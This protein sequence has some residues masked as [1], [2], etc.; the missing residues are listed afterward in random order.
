MKRILLIALAYS[1]FFNAN[2]QFYNAGTPFQYYFDINPDT[3]LH[4]TLFPYT[5]Q[6]YDLGIFSPS[7][8]VRFVADGA[9]SSG[10]TSA[11]ISVR[12]LDANIYLSVGRLD[13]V[14][15]S[16]STSWLVTTVAKPLNA[17]EP[18]NAAGTVWDNSLL[19]ISDHSASFGWAK[20]INDWIGSDKYLGLKYDDGSTVYYGWI[21]LQ[22]VSE[23]SCYVKEYSYS[24]S[25][26]GIAETETGN[27]LIFPNPVT[28]KFTVYFNG[29][30]SVE[31][32][33]VYD[34][35][36]KC[37]LKRSPINAK[38]EIDISAEPAGI[39][40]LQARA[41]NAALSLKIIKN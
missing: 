31:A 14:F 7:A 38:E 2:G 19:Y 6:L 3:L 33:E 41:K 29:N 37:I 34:M 16:T 13:S 5:H 35:T 26:A 20:N 17:G 12:A 22:C 18:I 23:D 11:Y 8:G 1:L 27:V 25:V 21:R 40:F 32:M 4:Y 15:D 24:S 10:G 39:Y 9:V 28:S 30:F 36:G